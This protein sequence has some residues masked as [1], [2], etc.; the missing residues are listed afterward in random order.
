MFLD[1]PQ[2]INIPYCFRSNTPSAM[3]FLQ[4]MTLVEGLGGAAT[5]IVVQLSVLEVLSGWH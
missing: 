2:Y 5:G 1:A 3:V 4:N